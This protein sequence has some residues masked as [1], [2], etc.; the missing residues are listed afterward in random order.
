MTLYVRD[1]SCAELK[2]TDPRRFDREYSK[3]AEYAWGDFYVE[4]AMEFFKDKYKSCGVEIG[5]LHYRLAYSQGDFASFDGRVYLSQWME[6]VKVCPDGPTYAERWPAL[7]LA[8]RED[9]SYINV[10]GESDRRGWR[11]DLHEGLSG[12]HPC[13]IFAGMSDEDWDALVEEQ[14]D[15]AD[16]EVEVVKYCKAIGREMYAHL[17]KSYEDV[18]SE[19][20]FIESCEINEITFEVEE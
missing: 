11:L 6:T 4:D 7:Y 5:D 2:K 16:L 10:T 17:R 15:E 18:T 9:G 20:A 19:E 8:C 1:L 12:D 14:Y 3:W 13:G